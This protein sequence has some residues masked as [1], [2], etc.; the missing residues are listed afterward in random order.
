[1]AV[2][3]VH[4]MTFLHLAALVALESAP[5]P[6]QTAFNY[7]ATELVARYYP[8]TKHLYLT[9]Y[10][11]ADA[12]L[13]GPFRKC[14]SGAGFESFW[15]RQPTTD[16]TRVPIDYHGF[17]VFKRVNMFRKGGLQ[18]RINRTVT[19]PDGSL[20]HLYVYRARHFVDHYLIKVSPT[21]PAVIEFCRGNEII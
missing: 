21:T 3:L 4:V 9:G 13:R 19:G 1:M 11:E 17:S 2:F 10:S 18:V 6:E 5:L 8:Q 7:F 14:F 12:S 20:T 15:Q 16:T